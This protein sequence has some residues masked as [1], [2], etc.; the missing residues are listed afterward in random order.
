MQFHKETGKYCLALSLLKDV[1]FSS[2]T[3]ILLLESPEKKKRSLNQGS[4][5]LYP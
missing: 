4:H 5:I 2:Q 3:L 1:H